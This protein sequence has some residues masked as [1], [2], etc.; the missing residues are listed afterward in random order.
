MISKK[1]LFQKNEVFKEQFFQQLLN[2][3]F[4][5]ILSLRN[6]YIFEIYTKNGYFLYP[7]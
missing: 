1:K 3:F 5:R 7:T 4:R 2:N 6:V